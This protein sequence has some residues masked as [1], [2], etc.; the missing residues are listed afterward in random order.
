MNDHASSANQ[1][2]TDEMWWRELEDFIGPT[3]T[4]IRRDSGDAVSVSTANPKRT[5]KD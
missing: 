5:V 2:M 4:V 3:V 1:P